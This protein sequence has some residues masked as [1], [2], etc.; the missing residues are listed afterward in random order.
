LSKVN[1]TEYLFLSTY[2]RAK[3]AS[4]LSRE[5]LERMVEAA[6]FDEAARILTECGY[7]EL[8]GATD[9]QVEQAFSARRAQ[10]LGEMER[11]CPEPQLVAAFRLKYDYHNAKVL[12][13]A[14]GASVDGQP[15]LSDCG[16]V[17]GEDLLEAYNSEDWRRVPSDL[18]RAIQNAKSTLAR[19][20]NP[21]L[22]DMELD[23]AY[24]AAL[25]A[26]SG[27][28]STDFYTGYVRL[29][30]DVAN[31][32]SAVRCIRG[33]MD[34]GVLK[35]ALIEGGNLSRERI[36]RHVYPEG[37][38]AVFQAKEL[39][40]A[41]Q[42]GQNAIEGAPL[43]AFERECDNVLT[44]HLAE[45]KRTAFGPAV[46][47]AYLACLDGEITAARMVLLGKRS[48]L[49]PETLRERLRDCYV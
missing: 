19:T 20:G 46:A 10:T 24:F 16:R 32:R 12:V 49:K 15:L 48:G 3:E 13:K 14:E 40:Q 1:D 28:L 41:A 7:P 38:S 11:F 8:A 4:L 43:A 25:L 2:L 29:A 21:Q 17:S 18:A 34:E 35:T 45:A 30:I 26:L 27:T 42:L 22:T 44:R 23:K 9:R 5:R 36:A 33:H 6:D 37:V 47:V 31:L 39:A